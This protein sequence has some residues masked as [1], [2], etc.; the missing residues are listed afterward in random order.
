MYQAFQ[1]AT[2]PIY[3]GVKPA[4]DKKYLA[5]IRTQASVVS[6]YGGCDACHTGPHGTGQK[7]SDFSTIPLTR[8]EHDEFDDDPQAFAE[9][10]GLNIPALI[11]HYNR[12]WNE[13]QRRSA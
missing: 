13:R 5:F 9:R 2:N 11:N 12:L 6:G 3:K 7:S 1:V 8:K 4:R 10:H